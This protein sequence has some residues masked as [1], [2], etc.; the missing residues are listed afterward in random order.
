MTRVRKHKIMF[1]PV[2]NSLLD[3]GMHRAHT[4]NFSGYIKAVVLNYDLASIRTIP[5]SEEEIALGNKEFK[6]SEAGRSL[7]EQHVIN[8]R[9]DKRRIAEASILLRKSYSKIYSLYRNGL[10]SVAKIKG[11]QAFEPLMEQDSDTDLCFRKMDFQYDE[12]QRKLER[13]FDAVGVESELKDEPDLVEIPSYEGDVSDKNTINKFLTKQY[14]RLL[15][16]RCH[17]VSFNAKEWDKISELKKRENI[18]TE[19]VFLKR[20]LF[21]RRKHYQSKIDEIIHSKNTDEHIIILCNHIEEVIL[22]LRYIGLRYE[23]ELE[24][25]KEKGTTIKQR[26]KYIRTKLMS[27]YFLLYGMQRLIDG[28]LITNKIEFHVEPEPEIVHRYGD[29]DPW[30]EE[31]DLELASRIEE[32]YRLNHP[33]EFEDENKY[34]QEKSDNGSNNTR[35]K[36]D[37]GQ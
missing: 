10:A 2:E 20:K 25:L 1:D 16:S 11:K 21:G 23:T 15:D 27:A 32:E 18:A 30:M 12:L 19:T 29:P 6:L 7:L 26:T 33:E 36:S 14:H 9:I 24:F 4:T 35:R 17:R 22:K 8:A 37:Y 34:G 5:Y 3:I 31:N 13:L 28:I